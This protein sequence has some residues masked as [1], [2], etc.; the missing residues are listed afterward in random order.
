MVKQYSIDG[1]IIKHTTPHTL[2][3]T[4]G[5]RLYEASSDLYL[6]AETLGYSSVETTRKHYAAMSENRKRDARN[7]VKPK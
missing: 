3:R 1:G 6:V 5:T 4:Y 7:Q 2:S